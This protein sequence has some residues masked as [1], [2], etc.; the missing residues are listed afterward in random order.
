MI[1]S[2][3]DQIGMIKLASLLH[4]TRN[5]SVTNPT[6]SRK[7]T[8]DIRDRHRVTFSFRQTLAT[9]GNFRQTLREALL[10]EALLREALPSSDN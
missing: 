1:Y 9:F 10:R 6:S 7:T 4:V 3:I 8:R 2:Q 5:Q